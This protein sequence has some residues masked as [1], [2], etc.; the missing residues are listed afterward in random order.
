MDY[1]NAYT[2]L[3]RLINH[4][5]DFL[6]AHIGAFGHPAVSYTHLVYEFDILKT[7]LREMAFLTKGLKISLTDLR[8]EEPHTRTFHYEGGIRELS[9]IHI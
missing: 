3:F 9:L 7:R 1:I 5:F 8:G 2:K 4:I 6:T